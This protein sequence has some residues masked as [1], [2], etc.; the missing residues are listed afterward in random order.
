MGM[1][2]RVPRPDVTESRTAGMGE[3]HLGPCRRPHSHDV[4]PLRSLGVPGL[5]VEASLRHRWHRHHRHVVPPSVAVHR[6][7]PVGH[8]GGA[9]QRLPAEPAD[10]GA[11]HRDVHRASRSTRTDA[12]HRHREVD[13]N[14]RPDHPVRIHPWLAVHHRRRTLVQRVRP[15]LRRAAHLGEEGSVGILDDVSATTAEASW[16]R[17]RA[18]HHPNPGSAPPYRGRQRLVTRSSVTRM[19][20]RR[21]A[22]A[23]TIVLASACSG[24]SAGYPATTSGPSLSGPLSQSASLSA[25]PAASASPTAS[26]TPTAPPSTPAPT[27]ASTVAPTAPPA[28]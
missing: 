5:C 7:V 25:S 12:A 4:L 11:V 27:V 1:D 13:R 21:L 2:V 18:L 6:R 24:V 17:A 3:S 22:F 8:E 10:V 9:V 19:T 23:A 15:R 16:S 28:L 14:S 20:P 26:A